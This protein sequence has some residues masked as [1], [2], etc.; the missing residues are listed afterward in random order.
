MSEIGTAMLA[1]TVARRLPRKAKITSTTSTTARISSISTWSTEA[2]MLLVRS[3]ST[4]MRSDAGSPACSVGNCF[5]IASTVAM[6]LAPGWRCT[7]MMMAGISA[8]PSTQWVTSAAA[9]P[10]EPG[11]QARPAQAPSWLFSA[12][13]TI[14][15]TSLM[16]TGALFL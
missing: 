8:A 11:A 16:R 9:A 6:T 14:L 3:A 12:P 5:L 7:F 4:S 13:W 15:A 1:I 10:A 2:R